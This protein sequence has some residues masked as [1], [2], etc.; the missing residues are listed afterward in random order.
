MASLV[1][2]G[3]MTQPEIL[4]EVLHSIVRPTGTTA[5]QSLLDAH[6]ANDVVFKNPLFSVKGKAQLLHLFHAWQSVFDD[7]IQ[8]LDV[9]AHGNKILAK[10]Q[11]NLFLRPVHI[12]KRFAPR[13]VTDVLTFQF[14][15]NSE[16]ETVQTAQGRK[17]V[18]WVEDVSLYTLL[19][20]VFWWNKIYNTWD[21]IEQAVGQGVVVA[22][23]VGTKAY[24]LVHPHVAPHA[25][26]ALRSAD[27]AI[28]E[29][30]GYDTGLSKTPEY[31]WS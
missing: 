19:N 23:K 9:A 3:E 17:I 13:I 31:Y 10:V 2:S 7:N 4:K 27:R 25:D 30:T 22:D 29:Y 16:I 11:H 26:R 14:I 28:R 18:T 1:A 5:L 6:F 8:V 15:V 20:N 24:H 21:L 12:V